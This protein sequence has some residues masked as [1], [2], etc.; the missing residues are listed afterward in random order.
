MDTFPNWMLVVL[1]FLPSTWSIGFSDDRIIR[2][3][4]AADW[5]SL[6]ID[7]YLYSGSD[8]ESEMSPE[9]I[10]VG[11][12]DDRFQKP[13]AGKAINFGVNKYYPH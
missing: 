1:V 11:E 9:T 10:A 5:K 13:E 4:H 3:D 2:L 12:F 8:P 6:R 7:A